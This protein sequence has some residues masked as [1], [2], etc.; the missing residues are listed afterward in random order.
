MQ[1]SG[2]AVGVWDEGPAGGEIQEGAWG[3][4][5]GGSAPWSFHSP[6]LSPAPPPHHGEPGQPRC[7]VDAYNNADG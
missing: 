3:A 4:M 6:P 7:Q 1:T 5:I 2:N